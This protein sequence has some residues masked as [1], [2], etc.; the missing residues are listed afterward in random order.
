ME[1]VV[2]AGFR[3]LGTLPRPNWP[4]SSTRSAVSGPLCCFRS[5]ETM[6]GSWG[7]ASGKARAVHAF[8]QAPETARRRNHPVDEK[9]SLALGRPFDPSQKADI[10]QS[11]QAHYEPPS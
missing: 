2:K 5:L 7:T 1:V 8:M 6:D 9:G 11:I 10:T 3:R 4:G